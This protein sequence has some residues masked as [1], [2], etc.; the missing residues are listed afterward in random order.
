MSENMEIT[1][2]NIM[3]NEAGTSIC[4]IKPEPG[5][6][7]QAKTIYNAMNNPTYN[8][9]D[10]VNKTIT[11]EN[12]LIEIADILNEETGALDRVPRTVLISPDG[13]SYQ[14]TSKGVFTSIKNAYVALG[15]APWVGGIE[16]TVKQ[17]SVGR[18]QMLTLEMA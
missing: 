17:K 15:N 14:A 1:V 9:R 11:V 5:N 2:A 3:N 16:F 10:F 4:S 18:G 13:T 7:E 8:L 12:V 6:K